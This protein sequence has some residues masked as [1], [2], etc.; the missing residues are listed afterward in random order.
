MVQ[1]QLHQRVRSEAVGIPRLAFI[2]KGKDRSG[3]N[4]SAL[5][6]LVYSHIWVINL[7]KVK[8]KR[9]TSYL[10]I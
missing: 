6:G 9:R 1:Q 10:A 7:G 2:A 8:W 5:R 3:P 4:A